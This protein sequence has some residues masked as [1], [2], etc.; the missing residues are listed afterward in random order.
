MNEAAYIS[1]FVLVGC[2]WAHAPYEV[3][4]EKAYKKND[5]ESRQIAVT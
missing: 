5:L 4:S 2:W 1:N 3:I